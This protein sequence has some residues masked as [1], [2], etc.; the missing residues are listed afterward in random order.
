MNSCPIPL[1]LAGH[2]A[3]GVLLLLTAAGCEEHPDAPAVAGASA[4]SSPE[5]AGARP[6]VLKTE[7]F[8]APPEKLLGPPP[9]IGPPHG[10]SRLAGKTLTKPPAPF[11]SAAASVA[12][13][14]MVAK[15]QVYLNEWAR[16]T[17][18]WHDLS[19]DEQETRRAALKH[20]IL[21]E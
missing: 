18:S 7:T 5:L 17:S 11:R 13:A 20:Q 3:A 14:A 21:G 15:Q 2:L 16:Q 8:K 6:L 19:A 1:K 12:P 9:P 4:P 10:A